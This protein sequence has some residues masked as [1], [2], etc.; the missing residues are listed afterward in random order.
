MVL[1]ICNAF[2]WLFD[3]DLSSVMDA[4]ILGRVKDEWRNQNNRN[5][6]CIKGLGTVYQHCMSLALTCKRARAIIHFAFQDLNS[7]YPLFFLKPHII[8]GNAKMMLRKRIAN[9]LYDEGYV[10]KLVQLL[11]E[12][13]PTTHSWKFRT[14]S[15]PNNTL[16]LSI[17]L[18]TIDGGEDS[19]EIKVWDNIYFPYNL[20]LYE[21]D[22][23]T[24]DLHAHLRA[25]RIAGL[26]EAIN[27]I[28]PTLLESTYRK[29]VD[30]IIK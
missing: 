30:N 14:H 12:E 10:V 4:K 18:D 23:K 11:I 9:T 27:R 7:F 25:M 8:K 29:L 26:V 21:V 16:D 2:V 5:T 6:L 17:L 22:D 20:F 3:V 1:S 24:W 15:R 28:N 19:V 13:Y